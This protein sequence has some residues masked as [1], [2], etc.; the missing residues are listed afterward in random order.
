MMPGN[1]LKARVEYFSDWDYNIKI[2]GVKFRQKELGELYEADWNA[3][4]INLVPEPDNKYDPNAVMIMANHT[5][6]GYLPAMVAEAF[7]QSTDVTK[8]KCA[9]IYITSG[10]RGKG[11]RT[12]KIALKEI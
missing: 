6:I 9:L 10:E 11:I 2:A 7:S 12:A 8:Y 1:D 5:H 3:L 4:E